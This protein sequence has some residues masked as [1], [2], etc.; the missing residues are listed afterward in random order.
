[1]AMAL[2]FTGIG[3]PWTMITISDVPAKVKITLK[4]LIT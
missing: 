2:G 3:F 4:M 1:M